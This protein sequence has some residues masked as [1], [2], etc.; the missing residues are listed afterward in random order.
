MNDDNFKE[1]GQGKLEVKP[2]TVKLITYGG[3]SVKV[4]GT[5]N[6]MLNY[7]HQK[8]ESAIL[9]VE[10]SGP[11]SIERDWLNKVTLD[12]KKL[13]KSNLRS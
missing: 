2:A 6:I 1:I 8:E 9:I 5:V 3:E 4:L 11:N 12:W 13:F 7:D 10:G